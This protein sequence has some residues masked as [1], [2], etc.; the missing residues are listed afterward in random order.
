MIAVQV[1]ASGPR[2]EVSDDRGGGVPVASRP[3][4][5]ACGA[6]LPTIDGHC[7]AHMSLATE[8]SLYTLSAE[9]VLAAEVA[10]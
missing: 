1:V 2:Y 3:T 10:R 7:V 9:T 4:C 6:H 8:I 5:L